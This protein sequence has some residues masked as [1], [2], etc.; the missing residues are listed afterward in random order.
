MNFGLQNELKKALNIVFR[1]LCVHVHR[2]TFIGPRKYNI[3]VSKN[4]INKVRKEVY[5]RVRR[6]LDTENKTC[7]VCNR[8]FHYCSSCGY[9]INTHPFSE[10]YCCYECLNKDNGPKYLEDDNEIRIV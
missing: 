3:E 10:G 7:K 4:I 1:E 8:R 2:K 5:K 9:D 6:E